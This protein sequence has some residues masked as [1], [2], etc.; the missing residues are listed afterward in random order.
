MFLSCTQMA[1]GDRRAVMMK[2]NVTNGR[3]STG[4]RGV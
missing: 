2:G 4:V 3:I 1:G